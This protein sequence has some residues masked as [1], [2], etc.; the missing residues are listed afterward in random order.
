M[1]KTLGSPA[2]KMAENKRWILLP[3]SP[4]PSSVPAIANKPAVPFARLALKLK[5]ASTLDEMV[6][7][8]AT[9]T[10]NLKRSMEL[11]SAG[12]AVNSNF[13]FVAF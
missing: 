9:K 13:K 4:Q 8:F 5:M 10:S 11:R 12:R 3:R 7:L 1:T 2:A 6:A